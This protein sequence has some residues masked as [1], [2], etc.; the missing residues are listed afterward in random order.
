MTETLAEQP[1]PSRGSAG[2]PVCWSLVDGGVGVVTLS[3]PARRNALS[4]ALSASLAAAVGSALAA[5]ARALV[6]AAEPPVF[7]AGGSLDELLAPT[8][9]LEDT[10]AGLLALDAAPVVTVAAVGGPAIGAGVNLPLACDV[11]VVTPDAVFDPRWLDVDIHPG[12]GHLYRLSQRV[13]PQRAAA[14][15]LCGES[16][17][18]A[19]AVEAGLAYRC[20]APDALLDTAIALAQGAARRDPPLVARTKSTLRAAPPTLDEAIALELDAQRWSM[21]RA[22]FTAKVESI[23]R[24]LGR[25]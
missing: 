24:R 7:C 1:D 20:V 12:G 4:P 19:A 8:V 15:V 13:G 2:G 16:V 5:G 22:E 9:P 18:G 11:V 17:E 25:P 6:L 21:A 10:Y 14:L 23:R 3:D